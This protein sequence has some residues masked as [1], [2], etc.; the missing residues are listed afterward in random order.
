MAY[1]W[2]NRVKYLVRYM[3]D[4]DNNGFLDKNDFDCLAVRVTLIE[5]HGEF[6]PDTFAS[7][8]KIMTNLW[9]EIAELA[10]FNK[11]GEVSVE[12]FK[13]AVYHSLSRLSFYFFLSPVYHSLS[14]STLPGDGLVGVDE[15]RL[16][17][18]TRAAFADVKEIDDAFDK[19]CTAEDKKAGGIN[20]TRYQELYAEFISN[21][22]E[23]CNACYL[24]GPLKVVQ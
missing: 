7:N 12:S 6:S 9:N 23:N 8:Q 19:L 13:A 11:D 22:D 17:C 4:I 3:Y 20:K 24:F 2:D 5:G 16:D 1:S 10:D 15:Y 18:I 14:S 21:T